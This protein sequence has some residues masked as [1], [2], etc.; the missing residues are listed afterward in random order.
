M[1]LEPDVYGCVFRDGKDCGCENLPVE[2]EHKPHPLTITM[3]EHERAVEAV[4]KS[5]NW[6]LRNVDDSLED[7][8]LAGRR[9]GASEA[10]ARF[11][12]EREATQLDIFA[13][14]AMAALIAAGHVSPQ[15]IA[16]DAY[17]IARAMMAA[18]FA[19]QRGES[20]EDVHV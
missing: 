3:D 18:R 12:Q 17:T 16:V 19:E 7:S 8:Y 13:Q 5:A 14:Q 11:R 4:V 15:R 6:A 2:E 20:Y 1:S 10:E 9:D